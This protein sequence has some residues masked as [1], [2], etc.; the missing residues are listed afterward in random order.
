M[1]PCGD[2]GAMLWGSRLFSDF[3][4]ESRNLGLT[5]QYRGSLFCRLASRLHTGSSERGPRK[6]SLTAPQKEQAESAEGTGGRSRMRTNCT[7]QWKHAGQAHSPSLFFGSFNVII[8]IIPPKP[9]Y[10]KA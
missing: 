4:V 9:I 1:G 8:S 10:S 3:S 2:L 7:W 5:C 6:Q